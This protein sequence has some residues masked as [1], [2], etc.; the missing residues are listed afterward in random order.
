MHRLLR[1]QARL[2]LLVLALGCGMSSAA[3]RAPSGVV[4]SYLV[5]ASTSDAA[6]VAVEAAGGV[7]TQRLTIIDGVAANL[8]PL[9]AVRLRQDARLTL[10]ADRAV[11]ATGSG[12]SRKETDTAG[13]LLFPAAATNAHLLHRHRD[14]RLASEHAVPSREAVAK[15]E[16]VAQRESEQS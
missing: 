13:T 6:T 14:E 16:A 9:A 2:L 7:V 3:P 11:Y 12:D 8:S 15:R 4:A 10:H 5:Q 1:I